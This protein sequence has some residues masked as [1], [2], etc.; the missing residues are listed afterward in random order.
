MTEFTT[1]T[2]T[3][4]CEETTE[5]DTNTSISGCPECDGTVISDGEQGEKHCESCGLVIDS[6]QID[7]GPEWRAFNATERE[8]RRRVG[9]PMTKTLHDDGLSTNISW[10]NRDGNGNTLSANQRRKMAR[11]RKW[12]KRSKSQNGADRTLQHALGEINRMSSAL[13]LPQHVQES[14]SILFRQALNDDL[15]R[16]R[17]IE[18]TSAALLHAAARQA[19][20]PRAL[21]EIDKVSKVSRLRIERAYRQLCCELGLKIPPADPSSYLPRCTTRLGAPPDVESHARDILSRVTDAGVHIGRSP[22]SVVAACL[23]IAVYL[24]PTTKFSQEEIAEASYM[25]PSALRASLEEICAE[26]SVTWFTD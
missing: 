21:E 19:E 15:I 20:T 26:A 10:Q 7:R 12:N 18:S 24:D 9:S 3:S 11:L 22:L 6:E 17:A 4:T 16:G 14:A 5:G 2:K 13:G 25:S 1:A 23:Y 8:N